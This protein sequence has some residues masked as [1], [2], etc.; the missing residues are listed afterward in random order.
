[1]PSRERS[2]WL[3]PGA[4]GWS[5]GDD[6]DRIFY[7]DVEEVRLYRLFMP[8]VAAIDKKVMWRLHLR[9]RS[10][11]RLVLSPLHYIRFRSW[12]DRS[13]TYLAF[14]NELLNRLHNANPLGQS[15]A[16]QSRRRAQFGEARG[17]GG[18]AGAAGLGWRDRQGGFLT[19]PGSAAGRGGKRCKR[20]TG[21]RDGG[22]RR[23]PGRH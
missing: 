23:V 18:P 20:A 2:F 6:E 3:E 19:A 15:I 21:R 22:R 1:M 4:L 7:R 11:E 16:R 5:Q 12:E 9:C 13:A 14:A 17:K 10:G 8:G